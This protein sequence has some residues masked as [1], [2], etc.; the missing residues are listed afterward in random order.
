MAI[1][2]GA[3]FNWARLKPRT[4]PPEATQA[5]WTAEFDQPNGEVL[6][7]SEFQGK[8]LVLNFWATWCTPCVEEMPLLNAFF[9]KKIRL[10]A[11]K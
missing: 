5:L 10:K 7:L 2:A 11:G 3:A 1:V 8:P 9:L 4:L 6:R